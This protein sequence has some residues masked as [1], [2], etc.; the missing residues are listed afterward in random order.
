MEKSRTVNSGRRAGGAFRW[1]ADAMERAVLSLVLPLALTAEAEMAKPPLAPMRPVTNG[2]FGTTVIDPFRWMENSASPELREWMKKQS[3]YGRAM[4]DGL[5]VRQEILRELRQLDSTLDTFPGALNPIGSRWFYMRTPPPTDV[6]QLFAREGLNGEQRLLFDPKILQAPGGTHTALNFYHAAPDGEH[7]VCPVSQGGSEDLTLRIV[8]VETARLMDEQIER[9]VFCCWLPNS[10]GFFYS[11][12]PRRGEDLP[13]V[14]RHDQRCVY[15]HYLGGP[16]EKDH[17][18]FGCGIGTNVALAKTFS[19]RV[20]AGWGSDFAVGEVRDGVGPY[21]ELYVAPLA[22][23]EGS[24]I[25]WRRV[26]GFVDEITGYTLDGTN[27]FLRSQKN[28]PRGELLRVECENAE[29]GLTNIFLPQSDRIFGSLAAAQD[30]LYATMR[31]DRVTHL[32]RIP[33]GSPAQAKEI[34]LPVVGSVSRVISDP[35]REGVILALVS[36]SEPSAYYSFD[37]ATD[38]FARLRLPGDE[39]AKAVPLEV[40]EVTARSAD[41]TAVPLTILCRPGLR[42]DGNRPTLLFGY[43]AY[44]MAQS[45]G[46]ELSRMPWFERGGVYAIAHVRGGGEFGREWQ[47]AGKGPKKLNGIADF[48]A[49]AEHL[50][51]AGYTSP[52]KLAVQS[53]SAGGVLVGRALTQRPDLFRAAVIESGALDALRFEITANGPPNIPEWG[54][55]K[56]EEGFAALRAMSPYE[57]IKPGTLYPAVLLTTGINDP[58]VDPWQSCKM[59]ARLQE[60]TTSGRPMLLCINYDEGHFQTTVPS[61]NEHQADIWT[62]LL[63]QLDVR[64]R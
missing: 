17:A 53:V 49:C 33:R 41:G 54:S 19:V 35:R 27:L 26:C 44:G 59:L 34:K 24:E 21:C 55:T 12:L 25:P 56:T 10:R 22:A 4:L 31:D 48:I 1:I 46:F 52:Q 64:P 50:I 37:P 30:A 63:W 61:M 8:A 51:T 9:A 38:G 43:G 42:R 57:H 5:P 3:D 7:V 28:A 18:V 39:S 15:L 29:M 36:W 40:K 6:Y 32:L 13:A 20:G 58:R 60:A 11:R 14:A 62:F 2:Y 47:L 45:P 23:T 16:V